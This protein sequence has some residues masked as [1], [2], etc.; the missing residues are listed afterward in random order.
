MADQIYMA[1]VESTYAAMEQMLQF[2][3]VL[4]VVSRNADEHTVTFSVPGINGLFTAKVAEGDAAGSSKVTVTAPIDGGDKAQESVAKFYKDLGD[5]LMVQGAVQSAPGQPPVFDA[6]NQPTQTF[7][8]PVPAAAGNGGNP[9]QGTKNKFVAMLTDTNTGKTSVMAIAAAVVSAVFLIFGFVSLGMHPPVVVGI[10]FAVVAAV[11]CALAYTKTQPGREHGR[12]L[13]VV[14][15]G[16]TVVAL[17]LSLVGAAGGSIS[18]DSESSDSTTEVTS[19]SSSASSSAATEDKCEI[20]RWPSY[21]VGKK[22]PVIK[23]AKGYY[24]IEDS[25]DIS[26]YI[27]DASSS[28]YE[29]YVEQLQKAGFNIEYDKSSSMFTALNENGDDVM[30]YRLESKSEMNISLTEGNGTEMSDQQDSKE[31]QEEEQKQAEEERKKAE[32]EQKRAEEEQKKAQEEEARKQQEQNQAQSGGVTP[33]VKEAMDSYE[34][35][36]NKYCDF[37]EKYNKEGA[38]ASMLTDYLSMLKEYNEM[39]KKIDDMD[40][41][42]W[43]SADTQYYLEVMNRVN[44]RLA[45]IS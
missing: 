21:G 42:S 18:S 16:V 37:M 29:D 13:T 14:A 31:A 19:P 20:V 15:A 7:Q 26:L 45:S 32:E 43:S 25:D 28:M 3:A 9:T 17:I 8:A 30:V 5:Q 11:L 6:Q 4:D 41:S 33:A 24:S 39:T 23:D 2:S 40:Q 10:I 35:Y 36:M 22:L 38:P 27:C 1:S 34:S 12:M 44:Q